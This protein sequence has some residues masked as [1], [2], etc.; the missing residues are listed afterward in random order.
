M[1]GVGR[2][3]GGFLGRHRLALAYGAVL[4]L[5]AG[6][7]YVGLEFGQ[8]A[9]WARPDEEIFAQI[10]MR[11]FG[12]DN[13][14]VAEGGWPELWFR[15]HHWVQRG[16]RAWWAWRYGE[17]LSLGCVFVLAPD[18]LLVP[19]R[20]L[21]ATFSVGTVALVMRL[22]WLAAPRR[23]GPSE[24]HAIA[25]ASGLFYAVDVLSSRDAHFAV[26]DQPL[27]FFMVWMFVAAARGLERG[28]L[29]DFF[30]CGIALG[31]GIG[32]KWAGLPFG[33]VPVIALGVRIVRHGAAPRNVGALVL[34][35]A[36]FAIAFLATNPTFLSHSSDF[37]NGVTSVALRYDP[38]APR[39]FSIY[40][41]VPI[42]YGITR[43]ARVSFPF[44]LGWPLTVVAG[45][46][47]LACLAIGWRRRAPATFLVGFWTI[48]FW[49]VVVGRTTL[50]FARYSMPAHPT[51][52][53]GAAILLVIVFRWLARRREKTVVR[54]E[55]DARWRMLAFSGLVIVLAAEPTW[56]S[57]EMTAAFARPDTRERAVAW[58]RAHAHDQPIDVVGGYSRPLAVHD[59]V[60]D[61][62]EEL[63]PASFG[64]PP[65][66]RLQ[67]ASDS[68]RLI[69]DRP[70]SWH[71]FAADIVYW[72]LLHN[73]PSATAH[74]MMV[75][76]PWLPCGQPVA[77]FAAYDPP[78]SC[79]REAARFEP[80]GVDCD[81]MWDDQDHF[82]SPLWGF[83]R[84]WSPSSPE[85]ARIG[86]SIVIY[87]RTCP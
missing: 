19:L 3:L 33:I 79:Y 46:G 61:R 78:A 5:A 23:M 43:H 28:W 12:D 48:F 13:P 68:S 37:T 75:A 71:P 53:V 42:E 87:E 9:P 8:S 83:S 55:A 21:A 62:C 56:R 69:T 27:V 25:L 29:I 54:S 44:G 20:I 49:V 30:T 4:L 38:N 31:L 72:G 82:Y 14:H 1:A 10:G 84:P 57:I 36:G 32:S 77:R 40:T 24:R 65:A 35:I 26:S 50:Y 17:D 51:A 80:E 59:R 39:A 81:A 7:R 2:A 41:E 63:L 67:G 70:A 18:R 60:A 73:A 34:G 16:L 11:L 22:G 74:W 85:A 47:A 58:M 86:P 64:A 45:L 6:L 52:C 66:L 76:Q 15:A